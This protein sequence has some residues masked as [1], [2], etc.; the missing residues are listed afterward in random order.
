MDNQYRFIKAHDIDF[1]LDAAEVNDAIYRRLLTIKHH[2]ST[3]IQPEETIH[4]AYYLLYRVTVDTHPETL[5]NSDYAF[6]LSDYFAT[7]SDYYSNM[8]LVVMRTLLELLDD[9]SKQQDRFLEQLAI[10]T[11]SFGAY[12]AT[13]D[14]IVSQFRQKKI[15][16]DID[17]TNLLFTEKKSEDVANTLTANVV[18]R[19]HEVGELKK[20]II[21]LEEE[22]GRLNVDKHGGTLKVKCLLLES[23]LQEIGVDIHNV[24]QTKIARLAAYLFGVT[25]KK[26][27]KIIQPGIGVGEYHEEEIERVNKFLSDLGL[28]ISI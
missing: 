9:I 27:Y 25:E 22:C 4:W 28:A 23:L 6:I 14:N 1:F 26:A 17:F 7:S 19:S 24:D 20:R 18:D 2:D 15:K 5:L 12:W 11:Y 3:D 21:E 8:V 16:Y 13:F 10:K